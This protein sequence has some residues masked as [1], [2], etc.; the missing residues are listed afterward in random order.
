MQSHNLLLFNK[1][2]IWRFMTALLVLCFFVVS[3]HGA[4]RKVYMTYILHGNMNYDRYVRPTIWENFPVIYNNLM[5]FMDQHPDF[6]GQLQFSGQTYGSLLQTA[7]HVIEHAKKIHQRGQ[8]NFTGTFYSEPVNVNMDGETN[9]RCAWLGT[10]IIESAIGETDGFYLQERAYHPQLPW[11]LHHSHVSWTPV[12]T[13]DD[14]WRPFRLKGMDGT[15]SVCVPITRGNFLDKVKVAPAN[16]LVSIEEDYE[17]PQTFVSAYKRVEAYNKSQQDITVEWITVKDYIRK[18]GVDKERYVD[19]SAKARHRE[20]GTYSRWTADPLDIQIQHLTNQ[21]MADMRNAKMAVAISKHLFDVDLDEDFASSGFRLHWE[22]L[23]WNIE[24]AELYPDIEPRFLSR[25]GKVTLLSKAEHQLLWAVNSD[26][27]GWYPLYEKR[28]ERMNALRNC[29]DICHYLI[30]KGMDVLAQQYNVGVHDLDKCYVLLN[31]ESQRTKTVTIE[32]PDPLDFVD[33][34]DNHPLR[35]S[36]RRVGSHYMM[37]VEVPMPQYGY[38]IVGARRSSKAS[39]TNWCSG[40]AI[41]NDRL[42]LSVEGEKVMFSGPGIKTEILLDTFQVKALAE[43]NMGKGDDVW[44]PAKAYGGQRI[45]VCTD[46][47]YPQLRIERQ[48]DWLIHLRQTFTLKPDHVVCDMHFEF[49]HPTLVRKEGAVTRSTFNPEGLNLV[50]KTGVGGRAGY[51]IPFGISEYSLEG[52]SYFCPLTSLWLQN[53]NLNGL[54]INPQ[55]GEQ[56]FSADL[57]TGVMKVYLGASTTSGPI[58][59]VS[60]TFKDSTDVDQEQ[61][62][63]AEPFHGVYNHRILLMPYSGSWQN[64][65]LPQV[66]RQLDQ[67]VY[68]KEIIRSGHGD[69]TAEG[70]F[71]QVDVPNVDITVIDDEG[72]GLFMRCNEREGRKTD[73]TV[74]IGSTKHK[75]SLPPFGIASKYL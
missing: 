9:Y 21:A 32:C 47:L 69:I 24:R 41:S 23:A 14:A 5:D 51:D 30:D 42:R 52:L 66:L 7:P 6:R 49:P 40:T 26:S 34:S 13:G 59:A 33:L 54:L 12:I 64:N 19:H 25:H 70:S 48:P 73:A 17:F 37:H 72:Q 22:P 8:L 57:T 4:P 31:F 62:W 60:L 75:I 55:T 43:M 15:S 68:C 2:R 36:V 65:H 58:G 1:R 53:S 61:A 3:S 63:Y 11:I 10:K 20:N 46:G 27:K 28:R 29:S 56:A 39:G 18:F 16:S 71:L 74:T 45:C 50:V 35:S 67:P 44:R 38:K